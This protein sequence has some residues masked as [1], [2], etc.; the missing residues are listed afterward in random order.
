MRSAFAA[1][2]M[3]ASPRLAVRTLTI[4]ALLQMA[5]A[6]QA[7]ADDARLTVSPAD[8]RLEDAFARRQLLVSLGGKDVTSECRYESS[9]P[10]VLSIDEGG[11]V[12]PRGPGESQITIRYGERQLTAPAAVTAFDSGR[13]IDFKNEIVPLLSRL[14]CN[15]GGCHGKATGQN[16][17]KLSLFGFDP[18]FD[19]DAI[20]LAAR[21]RRVFPASPEESLLLRKATGTAPHGGGQRLEKTSDPYRLF[22]R[23]IEQG[24]PRSSADAPAVVKLSVEPAQRILHAGDRQ[25]VAVTAEY[26]DG[27]RRDVTRE[28]QYASNL[29]LVAAVDDRGLVRCGEQTGE[30]AIMVRYMG[31]VAV[32]RAEAPHGAPS[33][34]APEFRIVNYVD[35]LVLAKWRQLGLVPSPPAGDAAFLRRVTID[36]CGRLPTAA[37]ARAFL[38]DASPAKREQLIDRLLASPEYPAYFALRWGSILRNSRLAGADEAAYAFHDWIKSMIARNRPYDEFVRGVVAAAGE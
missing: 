13:R 12:V 27:S 34:D 17:F 36:L 24:L 23:W 8:L 32:F 7:A 15:S 30:A 35:R 10:A 5:A 3:F 38:A 9:N 20:A 16:G 19:Y 33:A 4:L 14:G 37:E 1:D 26:S 2:G 18:E 29:D 28:A 11:F 31:Q 25:Q 22:V 6:S 21:G